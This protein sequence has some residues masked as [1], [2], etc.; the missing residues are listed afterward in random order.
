MLKLSVVSIYNVHGHVYGLLLTRFEQIGPPP[1]TIIITHGH[2]DVYIHTLF[3]CGS[4]DL[5]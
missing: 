5:K 3:V 1:F 4:G 2:A